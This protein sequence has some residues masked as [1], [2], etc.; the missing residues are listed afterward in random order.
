MPSQAAQPAQAP[1]SAQSVQAGKP[2]SL[3]ESA[4]FTD[5]DTS[6]ESALIKETVTFLTHASATDPASPCFNVSAYCSLR[7][8]PAP[9]SDQATAPCSELLLTSKLASESYFS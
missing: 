1:K 8:S 6:T 2:A 7:S 9:V 3:T 5:P 4:A